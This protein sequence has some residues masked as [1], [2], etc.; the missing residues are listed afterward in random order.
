MKLTAL[1][2][3]A[4]HLDL[5][6]TLGDGRSTRLAEYLDKVAELDSVVRPG[7]H[8]AHVIARNLRDARPYWVTANMTA[9]ID[10]RAV[11]MRDTTRLDEETAPPR[12]W[13]FAVFEEPIR[14]TELRG[15]QIIMHVVAWGP[16]A[17]QDNHPGYL[18]QTFNDLYR[19]PDEIAAMMNPVTRNFVG[20]W[21]GISSYWMPMGLR[22]GPNVLEPTKLDRQRVEAEGDVAFITRNTGRVIL[23]LWQM[24]GETL[25]DHSIERAPR[26]QA[27]R[28]ARAELPGEVTVITLRRKSPPVVNPGTGTSPGHRT[29]VEDYPKWVWV[30]S[31]ADRRRERR[32][33]AAHWWPKDPSL[34]I[35]IKPKVNRLAR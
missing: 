6:E 17:D 30:G 35:R 24:L 23:A 10:L 34:P 32:I 1:D 25:S 16:S 28:M 8:I 5:V 7:G 4:Q 15:R 13:G 27:R 20:R 22:I 2:V 12:K 29:W 31:G 3:L 9:P 26:A 19:E 33:I 18:V 14:F 21:H 11:D